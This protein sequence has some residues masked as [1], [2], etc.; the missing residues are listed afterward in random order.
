MVKICEKFLYCEYVKKKKSS[1][2]IAKENKWPLLDVKAWVSFYELQPLRSKHN[3]YA[4][5]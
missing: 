3:I 1:E 2:K 4:W 5:D